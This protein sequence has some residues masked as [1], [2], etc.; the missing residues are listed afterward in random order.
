MNET[1][2]LVIDVQQGLIDEGPHD[3]DAFLARLSALLAAARSAG[4]PVAHVQHGDPDDVSLAPGSPGWKLHPSVC[5]QADEPVFGKQFN[6]AFKDTGLEAWLRKSGISQLVIC[7]M[8]TEHCLDASIKSAF[9]KGFKVVVP[10]GAHTTLDSTSLNAPQ[11]KQ[12]YA[13]RIWNGRY[14]AVEPVESVL[15]TYLR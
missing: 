7:G 6:S 8:Q 3:R 15:T 12:W 10:A 4:I 9:E 13:E 5:P 11:I 1:A 14:A 2:L